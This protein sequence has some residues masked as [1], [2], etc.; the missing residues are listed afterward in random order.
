MDEYDT[1]NDEKFGEYLSDRLESWT[2]KEELNLEKYQL[3]DLE[4]E[5]LVNIF[6]I[7]N[8]PFALA[9]KDGIL[10]LSLEYGDSG[11]FNQEEIEGFCDLADM[12]FKILERFLYI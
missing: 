9:L 2:N 11:N 10:S 7:Y 4:K 8:L 5:F 1:Q 6:N 3:S 12:A